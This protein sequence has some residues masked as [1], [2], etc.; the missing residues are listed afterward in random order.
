MIRKRATIAD[1]AERSGMSRSAVSLVLNNRPGARLS[2]EAAARIREAA[3]ELDY[4]PN[5]MARGLR[6][7]KTGLIGFISD[8]VTVTRYASAMIRGA[9]DVAGA[10]EHTVLIAETGRD[11]GKVTEATR[12]MLDRGVDGL[13]FAVMAAAEIDIPEIPAEVP[14]VLCNATAATGGPHVLPAEWDAGYAMSTA[15]LDAGHRRIVLVGYDPDKPEP[16]RSCTI[17]DRYDGIFAGFQKYGVAP[18]AVS[19]T[20]V[21]EP[22]SGYEGMAHLLDA[23]HDF[24]AALCLNDRMAFGAMQQ[25]MMRGMRVPEDMSLS[26]FDDDVIATYVHPSL[27]TAGLPH[28]EMGREAMRM[29]LDSVREPER[30]L[31]PMPVHLRGT[32]ATV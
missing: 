5:P 3:V 11:L 7:G 17:G 32:I 22:E 1:V 10:A 28:E 25:L 2:A 14:F 4:R 30:R 20:Q 8:N 19:E 12:L 18:V 21:W 23:G 15:L 27:S 9:L 26:S 24:T 31:V 16:R 13:I 6:V 29:V